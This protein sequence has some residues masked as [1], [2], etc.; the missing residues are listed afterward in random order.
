MGA[1]G[2]RAFPVILEIQVEN[3]WPLAM[4]NRDGSGIGRQVVQSMSF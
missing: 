4:I 2:G 1:F 3:R